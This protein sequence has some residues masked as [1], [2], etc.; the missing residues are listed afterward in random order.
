[1]LRRLARLKYRLLR[2]GPYVQLF[3]TVVLLTVAGLKWWYILALG[4]LMVAV[5]YEKNYGLP[6]EMDVAMKSSGEWREIKQKL[7]EALDK[8]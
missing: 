5:W 6:E 3:N 1:M 8:K 2:V 7:N 4:G